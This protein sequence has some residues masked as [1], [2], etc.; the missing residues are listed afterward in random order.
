MGNGETLSTH[1]DKKRKTTSSG[2]HAYYRG[3]REREKRAN[4]AV[5]RPEINFSYLARAT[6]ML[7]MHFN[8]IPVECNLSS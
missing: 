8:S 2:M 5:H 3:G 1:T 6:S 7:E 4:V